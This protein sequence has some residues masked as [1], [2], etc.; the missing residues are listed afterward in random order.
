MADTNDFIHLP[1]P[2]KEDGRAYYRP[3]P[4]PQSAE[5]VQ[6]RQNRQSHGD[7]LKKSASDLSKFRNTRRTE[8]KQRN[9]PLIEGGIPLLL[10]IDPSVD[11]GFLYGLGF[12]IVCDL[13]DGFIVVASEDVDL[14]VFQEK[15]DNFMSEKQKSG[16]PANIYGLCADR[17]RL[18]LI[19]SK[20][21][22]EKWAALDETNIYTV[23]ISIECN[24]MTRSPDLPEKNENES[25]EDYSKKCQKCES[26][27]YQKTDDIAMKRQEQFENIVFAYDAVVGSYIENVDSFSVRVSINGEGLRDLV[28]NYGYIFE[29]I[30]RL[31]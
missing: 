21:L 27:Y 18:A 31:K 3:M 16:S 29:V 11:V 28:Q 9:L 12:E 7:K 24:G 26:E 10:Q 15:I 17:D 20:S 25:D 6:N 23:D 2:Q 19:L 30:R 4:I 8:R 22:Y 5:T 13:D 14:N 1:F